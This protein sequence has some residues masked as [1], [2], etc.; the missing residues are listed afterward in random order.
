MGPAINLRLD[1][2]NSHGSQFGLGFHQLA[3]PT[4]DVLRL[5]LHPL[6]QHVTRGYI[7]DEAHRNPRT[8]DPIIRV[9][10]LVHHPAP[11]ARHELA[12]IF[13]L[14]ATGAAL[15]G[16]DLCGDFVLENARGV[17]ESAEDVYGILLCGSY[18]LLFN[19]LMNWAK[20][21]DQ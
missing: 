10:I 13:E 8:P 6:H 18:D 9:A 21:Q 16:D 15:D 2:Y 19:V 17:V 14:G 20:M 12:H 5:L 1:T 3:Q 7:V 11:L 4:N